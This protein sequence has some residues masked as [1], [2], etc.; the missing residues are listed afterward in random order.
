MQLAIGDQ[1][2]F[3]GQISGRVWVAAASVKELPDPSVVAVDQRVER[4][5]VPV[6]CLHGQVD[7][8][9]IWRRGCHGLNDPALG[10]LGFA[11]GS[12]C[13]HLL[14]DFLHGQGEE[15]GDAVLVSFDTQG[16]GQPLGFR[17]VLLK[18]HQPDQSAHNVL[19]LDGGFFAFGFQGEA[20]MDL[21]C[22]FGDAQGQ[23]TRASEH[24]RL[25]IVAGEASAARHPYEKRVLGQRGNKS[26]VGA[27]VGLPAVQEIQ[28]FHD[29]LGAL[30][31]KD[32]AT[33]IDGGVGPRRRAGG[34]RPFF[35]DPVM[36]GVATVGEGLVVFGP[37]GQCGQ[38][39]GIHVGIDQQDAV[40]LGLGGTVQRQAVQGGSG[41]ESKHRLE[42][43]QFLAVFLLLQ[44]GE[45][46]LAQAGLAKG[47]QIEV[48]NPGGF[49]WNVGRLQGCGSEWRAGQQ[50]GQRGTDDPP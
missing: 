14:D 42:G 13:L 11:C 24:G 4:S 23:Q 46:L 40:L 16:A 8:G 32:H 7:V 12:V 33:L 3:L 36:D 2:G 31:E 20:S 27:E 22:G 37:L 1:E 47:V 44:F 48:Q 15:Q 49:M 39:G 17:L 41:I 38:L 25:G 6:L 50:T 9:R 18:G 35:V 29:A 10:R 26:G 43:V 45:D 28:R 5:Q 30:A 19:D 21:L 34:T